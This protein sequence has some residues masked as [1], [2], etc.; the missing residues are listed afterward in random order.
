MAAQVNIMYSPFETVSY[1]SAP[2]AW[3]LGGATIA[4]RGYTGASAVNPATI[5]SENS[6]RFST[7]FDIEK[8]IRLHTNW[9]DGFSFQEPLVNL[10]ADVN[11]RRWSLAYQLG[12]MAEDV[13][14]SLPGSPGGTQK[15][16]LYDRYH[17]VT[18]AFALNARWRVGGGV[19]LLQKAGYLTPE[20]E[21]KRLHAYSFDLGLHYER[22]LQGTWGA[23][24]VMGGFSLTNWGGRVETYRGNQAPLTTK[25]R[26]GL[27][28]QL[29][30]SR[31]WLNRSLWQ[32]A[33]YGAGTKDIVRAVFTFSDGVIDGVEVA[34]PIEALVA[35]WKPYRQCTAP[36]C[37]GT[38]NISEYNAFE[39][40]TWHLGIEAG[41]MEVLYVRYGRQMA[42]EYKP[43][44]VINAWGVG[45]DLDYLA[46]EYAG[47]LGRGYEAP[48]S[49]HLWRLT[50]RL[51][52]DLFSR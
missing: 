14:V 9:K 26:L 48:P 30:G 7:N 17:K 37:L 49:Q 8:E 36:P 19:N 6:L 12:R 23:A 25:M 10:N 45:I 4:L 29:A 43:N 39:Q 33:M 51:P 47:V 27:G 22:A 2:R 28:G 38:A 40:I 13:V 34:G 52:L 41:L 1:Q 5:G 16:E 32:V 20:L 15:V 18:A 44:A 42:P 50:G 21:V 24:R 3:A 31:K 11:W 35:A 46:L